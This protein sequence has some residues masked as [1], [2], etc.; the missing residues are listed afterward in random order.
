MQIRSLFLL[1]VVPGV[2]GADGP[3]DWTKAPG[4]GPSTLRSCAQYAF[5]P[6]SRAGS[7]YDL[8][9]SII[10][11]VCRQDLI[12]KAYAG[13][14]SAIKANCGAD[15]VL[16]IE[17]AKKIYNDYCSANGFPIPGYTYIIT[18]TVRVSTGKATAAAATPTVNGPGPADGG[19]GTAAPNPGGGPTVTVTTAPT[20]TVIRSAGAS[21]ITGSW[22]VTFVLSLLLILRWS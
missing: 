19:D 8:G 16:D 2:Y 18:A 1:A 11:C 15:A 13:I 9:C 14:E 10:S 5:N 7:V 22:A 20:V 12:E 6:Y 3:I 21:T 17:Q 4:G